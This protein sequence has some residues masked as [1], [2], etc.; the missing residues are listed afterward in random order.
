M[1]ENGKREEGWHMQN[2]KN[3]CLSFEATVHAKEQTEVRAKEKGV[4]AEATTKR[5]QEK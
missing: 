1:K 3:I 5:I 2:K 4:V